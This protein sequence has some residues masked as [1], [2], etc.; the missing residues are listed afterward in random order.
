MNKMLSYYGKFSEQ[1]LLLE[2]EQKKP[3]ELALKIQEVYSSFVNYFLDF[4]TNLRFR[5]KKDETFYFGRIKT[6]FLSQF[7]YS[8]KL[9][10]IELSL[11]FMEDRNKLIDLEFEKI[12]FFKQNHHET[13][14]HYYAKDEYFF[15]QEQCSIHI[16]D[17]LLFTQ[18]NS[19]INPKYDILFAFF[20]ALSKIEL[21][22]FEMK[23][24]REQQHQMIQLDEPITQTEL[25]EFAY[26]LHALK[27]Q[28]N[29]SI[30]EL[31]AS[32][33]NIFGVKQINPYE[34]FNVISNRANNKSIFLDKLKN[35][36]ESR[37]DKNFK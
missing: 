6:F 26:A 34:Y 15:N 4:E 37:I 21:Y 3:L 35:A 18:I 1:I 2:K 31:T 9:I 14:K 19:K 24:K 7:I 12:S 11:S 10:E 28:N 32:L 17:E 36:L 23:Q 25:A 16:F 20:Q 27:S 5:T 30:K 22:L 33:C 29:V 8:K 13:L